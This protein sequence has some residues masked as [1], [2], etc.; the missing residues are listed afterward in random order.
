MPNGTTEYFIR[1]II[2]ERPILGETSAFQ[3]IR[4]GSDESF[5]QRPAP[6]S[7]YPSIKDMDCFLGLVLE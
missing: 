6:F 5:K 3:N 2:D 4:E 7:F 1:D